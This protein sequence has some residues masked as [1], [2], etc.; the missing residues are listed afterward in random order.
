MDKATQPTGASPAGIRAILCLQRASRS[1]G[2]AR[3][4]SARLVAECQVR[5][6]DGVDWMDVPLSPQREAYVS[7]IVDY[8]ER[9]GAL[10]YEDESDQDGEGSEA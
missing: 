4:Y 6:V 8:L 9:E 10:E 7:E 5:R 2:G 1:G 3:T